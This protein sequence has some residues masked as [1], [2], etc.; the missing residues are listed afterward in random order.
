MT[1]II[2]PDTVKKINNAAFY[3][4]V[5]LEKMTLPFTGKSE[6]AYGYEAVFGYIL[7]IQQLDILLGLDRIIVENL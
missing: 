7:V 6:D 5:R 2:V 3:D 4:C 1:S